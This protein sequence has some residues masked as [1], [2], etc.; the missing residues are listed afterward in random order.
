MP[1]DL[2]LL[3]PARIAMISSSVN[4]LPFIVRLPQLNGLYSKLEEGYGLTSIKA[5]FDA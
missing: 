4:R 5:T 3:R 2:G 1:F